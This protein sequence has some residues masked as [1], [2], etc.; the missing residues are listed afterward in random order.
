MTVVLPQ[1]YES[2]ENPFQEEDFSTTATLKS[3][4][5]LNEYRYLNLQP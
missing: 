3:V 4:I 2:L 5:H 1:A